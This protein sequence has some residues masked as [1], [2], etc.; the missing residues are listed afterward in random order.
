MLTFYKKIINVGCG[1][2]CGVRL[3]CKQDYRSVQFRYGPP[4]FYVTNIHID[5][6]LPISA[7]EDLIYRPTKILVSHTTSWFVSAVP[8]CEWGDPAGKI[9]MCNS[10][11]DCRSDKAKVVS[12]ILTTSTIYEVVSLYSKTLAC[13]A[14]KESASLSHPPILNS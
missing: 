5:Y 8:S 14:D 13:E 11:V 4:N 10:V 12:S 3:L 9:W 7:I 1:N 2:A 6:L